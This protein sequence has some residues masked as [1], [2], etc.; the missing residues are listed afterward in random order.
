MEQSL[1][2]LMLLVA[3]ATWTIYCAMLIVYIQGLSS[4]ENLVEE[5]IMAVLCAVGSIWSFYM[6][7][8]C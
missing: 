6:V 8:N 7:I 4:T 3:F 1:L 2:L 5:K